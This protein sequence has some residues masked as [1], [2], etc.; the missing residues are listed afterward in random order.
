MQ[1]ILG[2]DGRVFPVLIQDNQTMP[3]IKG[4]HHFKRIAEIG[5][6][7]ITDGELNAIGERPIFSR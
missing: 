4:P 1:I 6:V 2:R 5:L 3:V 7:H